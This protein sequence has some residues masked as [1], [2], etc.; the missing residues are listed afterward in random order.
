MVIPLALA[1]EYSLVA[2][3]IGAATGPAIATIG[4]MGTVA[5]SLAA[6]GSFS[7]SDF[8]RGSVIHTITTRTTDTDTATPTT[9]GMDMIPA[10]TVLVT[11]AR[12]SIPTMIRV[13][14]IRLIRARM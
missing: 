3:P 11:T 8:S 9:M 4:G 12:A 7:I 13:V 2:R 14:T 1:Q 6:R 10:T 5:D